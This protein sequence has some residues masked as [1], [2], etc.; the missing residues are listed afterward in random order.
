MTLTV[1]T[2]LTSRL[3]RR[4]HK[5]SMFSVRSL[6]KQLGIS[7]SFMSRI[8]NDTRRLPVKHLPK[9]VS[10][11]ELDE[12]DRETLLGLCQKG[13]DDFPVA[14]ANMEIS[15]DY[16]VLPDDSYRVLNSWRHLAILDLTTC[17]DFESNPQWIA[18]R[19]NLRV[20]EVLSSLELLLSCGLLSKSNGRLTKTN[21]K[22]RFSATDSRCEIRNF[23][24]QSLQKAISELKQVDDVSFDDRCIQG[25][26]LAGN[27]TNIQKARR[28][29]V[30][31][32]YEVAEILSQGDAEEVF[33]LGVQLFPLSKPLNE[34]K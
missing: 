17:R 19:L 2:F 11:L 13:W 14:N 1:G 31:C 12:V 25:I 34:D 4:Q 3:R 30:K 26:T 20:S 5:Y 21:L 27:R 7:P 8:L 28:H 15:K 22:I 16:Q 18:K 24:R 33:Q 29:L 6:A 32:L 23:H 10:V 9:I